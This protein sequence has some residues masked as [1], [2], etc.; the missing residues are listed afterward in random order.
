MPLDSLQLVTLSP[1][2]LPI[3]LTFAVA[4]L[5]TGLI[6]KLF[7]WMKFL[8]YPNERSS[9]TIPKPS[10]GGI[11]ILVAIGISLIIFELDKVFLPPGTKLIFIMAIIIGAISLLDD[12]KGLSPLSR[13]F[14]QI[15]CISFT[16]VNIELPNSITLKPLPE[17]VQLFF[18]GM[19]WLWFMNLYNFMD[20]IDAIT[21][22]ETSFICLSII[23]L[24]FISLSPPSLIAPAAIIT[25]ASSGFLVWNWPPSK[26]FLGDAGSVP[27]GFLV[28][29]LLIE[30]F[31]SGYW[32][33]A[34]ILPGYYLADATLTLMNR[35]WQ[36]KNI[37][38]SHQEHFYQRAFLGGLSHSAIVMRLIFVNLLLLSI[39]AMLAREYPILALLAAIVLIGLFLFFLASQKKVI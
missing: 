18:V 23:F 31:F 14:F 35:L 17:W 34:M 7:F 15:L 9:H 36:G 2:I 24:S 22:V 10:G 33:V 5:G 11:A 4:L 1:I 6:H 29:W 32:V 19:F 37:W 3:L 28:G 16:I 20:G 27:L 12:I 25:A 39:S 38:R 21:S 30:V 13:L 8:D 26:L